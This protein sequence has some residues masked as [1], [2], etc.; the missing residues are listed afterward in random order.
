MLHKSKQAIKPCL[1]NKKE[2]AG[3]RKKRYRASRMK[4]LI[5]GDIE[6]SPGP[7]DSNRQNKLSL[8]ST[9]LLNYCLRQLGLRPI[10]VRGAGDCF[11]EPFHINYMVTQ[12]VTFTF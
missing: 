2:P 12:V 3:S 4:L 8:S 5:S 10:D 11:L 9:I 7:E 1:A 6:L